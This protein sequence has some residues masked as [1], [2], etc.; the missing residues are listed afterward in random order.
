MAHLKACPNWPILSGKLHKYPPLNS[1]ASTAAAHTKPECRREV[2]CLEARQKGKI[3]MRSGEKRRGS[4]VCRSSN[5]S[6]AGGVGVVG[7]EGEGGD[8]GDGEGQFG[9]LV[10][11]YGWRVRRLVEEEDEMRR[12]AYVQA[13]AFHMPMAVFNDFFFEFFQA[14]VLAALIYKLRNSPPNR[15]ACLVAE[16]TDGFDFSLRPSQEGVVGVVDV[17]V[18]RDDD[19]LRHLD[20]AEEYL[21]ISGIAVLT[22]FRRQKVATVL[23]KACDLLSLTWGFKY[24]ALRAYEDDSAARKL[25]SN[26]GYKVVSR[27]PQW[28]TTWIGRKQRVLMIKKSGLGDWC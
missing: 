4:L 7:E 16:P 1:S 2:A 6:S 17:T 25:Y 24:L 15:Y 14:E 8:S 3:V 12:V 22:D 18:M 11:E 13:Q 19:I 21:Y 23:L 20:G 28:M 26:A 10:S 27:D 9:Y 5:S